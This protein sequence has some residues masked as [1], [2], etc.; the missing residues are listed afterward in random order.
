MEYIEFKNLRNQYPNEVD[1]NS[2]YRGGGGNVTYS[3]KPQYG[4]TINLSFDISGISVVSN[5]SFK[6]LIELDGILYT[7]PEFY[8]TLTLAQSQG[9]PYFQ[10]S[11]VPIIKVSSEEALSDLSLEEGNAREVGEKYAEVQ[12]TDNI[13]QG[14]S[15]EKIIKHIDWL[16]SDQTEGLRDIKEGSNR[17]YGDYTLNTTQFNIIED[18]GLGFEFTDAVESGL[19]KTNENKD[20]KVTRRRRDD[21][22]IDKSYSNEQRVSDIKITLPTDPKENRLTLSDFDSFQDYLKYL[23]S[24]RI[25]ANNL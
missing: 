8:S 16:V 6:F 21:S 13:N 1:T 10:K 3:G 7:S 5:T 24:N 22:N 19:G 12:V 18:S 4:N 23:A 14:N 25:G 9:N 11:T 20:V 15:I 17:V 2:S